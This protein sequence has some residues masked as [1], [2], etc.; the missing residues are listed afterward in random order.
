M[1]S[2]IL[3][4]FAA[5]RRWIFI[6]AILWSV[7]LVF[8]AKSTA[9]FRKFQRYTYE[10]QLAAET[11]NLAADLRE[12]QKEKSRLQ[13]ELEKIPELSAAAAQLR[14]QVDAQRKKDAA[15]WAA[16]S[17]LLESAIEQKQRELAEITQW[18]SEW[19]TAKEFE[20]AQ[21]RLE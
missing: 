5:W 13:S 21:T 15:A 12:L 8:V 11:E 4:K 7:V 3:S 20:A 14:N 1:I 9:G 16:K 17:N 2:P 18:S 6:A 19:H 10:S